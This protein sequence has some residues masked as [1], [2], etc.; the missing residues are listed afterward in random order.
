MVEQIHRRQGRLNSPLTKS[1]SQF[2]DE[3]LQVYQYRYPQTH[4]LPI[5]TDDN[6]GMK[7]LLDLKV[8]LFFTS[9]GLQ[10]G[11]DAILRGKGPIPS[12][13]PVGYDGIAFIINKSNLDSC[14]TVT[15]VK[16]LLRGDVTKWNQI[17]PQF[18]KRKYRSSIR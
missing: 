13:F 4:L 15:D 7:M 5:Y 11:E 9:H 1:F 8:N 14:I 18:K 16:R 12:V 2:L 10:K 17:Y 3:E 6:T